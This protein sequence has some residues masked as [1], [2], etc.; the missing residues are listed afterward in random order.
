MLL[1][2]KS[3]NIKFLNLDYYAGVLENK[4]VFPISMSEKPNDKAESSRPNHDSGT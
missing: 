1:W 3:K 2:V 4:E